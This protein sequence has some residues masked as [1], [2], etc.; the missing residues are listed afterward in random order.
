MKIIIGSHPLEKRYR[1]RSLT[2]P[3]SSQC[4]QSSGYFSL[5]MYPIIQNGIIASSIGYVT[6]IETVWYWMFMVLGA[7]ENLLQFNFLE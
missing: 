2:P 3:L 5:Q 4:L 1:K 7:F 6:Y